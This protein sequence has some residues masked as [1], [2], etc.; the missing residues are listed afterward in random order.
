MKRFTFYARV[1]LLVTILALALSTAAFA[2][3]GDNTIDIQVSPHTLNLLSNGGAFTIHAE[4]DYGSVEIVTLTVDGAD[5]TVNHP[6]MV[7]EG[8]D[9]TDCYTF[10]D[11]L[12]DLVVKCDLETVK[13]MVSVGEATFELEAL[14]EGGMTY[15]G[16]DTIDVI[17]RGKQR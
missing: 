1:L 17:S 10:A 11:D 7:E 9:P 2:E 6:G 8:N 5:L 4:V 3:D 12:G 13:S 14:T 15:T 16:E